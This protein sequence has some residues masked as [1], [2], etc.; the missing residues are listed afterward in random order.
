[1]RRHPPQIR[2][3]AILLLQSDVPL[4][5]TLTSLCFPAQPWF[6]SQRCPAAS[7][8]CAAWDPTAYDPP[9]HHRRRLPRSRPEQHEEGRREGARRRRGPWMDERMG[10][11]VPL[12]T[13]SLKKRR[14]RMPQRRRQCGARRTHCGEGRRGRGAR[15]RG[16]GDG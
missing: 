6:A 1:M 9:I 2:C 11:D 8:C 16:T 5:S 3:A 10:E 4:F 13:W 14:S 15:G 7:H 12:G